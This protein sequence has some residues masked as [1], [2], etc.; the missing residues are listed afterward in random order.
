[1]IDAFKPNGSSPPAR[2]DLIGENHGSIV[3][4]RGMTDAGYDWIEQNVSGG[5]YQTVGL[6]ARLV[7]PRYVSPILEG[8]EAHGFQM[9]G[10]S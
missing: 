9:G 1:V 10:A 2:A 6:G 7:E 8:A 5:G 3:I 4:L